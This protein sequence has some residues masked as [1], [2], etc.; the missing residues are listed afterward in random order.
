[1]TAA[2]LHDAIDIDMKMLQGADESLRTYFRAVEDPESGFIIKDELLYRVTVVSG[3]EIGQ[4]L[5]RS[6]RGCKSFSYLMIP[7]I[8]DIMELERRFKEFRR[9]F[10]GL[11]CASRYRLMYPVVS[12]VS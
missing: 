12:C 1:L 2:L 3:F 10:G 5:V 7:Y 11:R 8:R 6:E 4:L 9:I